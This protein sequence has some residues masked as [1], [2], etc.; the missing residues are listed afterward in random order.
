VVTIDD[1]PRFPWRGLM[2]DAGRHFIPV[3]V[4]ERN[5]DGMEAVKL[6]VFHWHL[7][8]DQGFR[9]ESKVFPELQGKGSG[10]QFYTQTASRRGD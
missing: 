3:P 1:E 5:L 7:S 4:I 6:N 8:E 9:V 10:G 2:I